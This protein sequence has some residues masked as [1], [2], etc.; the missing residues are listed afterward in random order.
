MNRALNNPHFLKS[1]PQ[2]FS[3]QS[4]REIWPISTFQVVKETH[5]CLKWVLEQTP[6]PT[7]IEAQ[8]TGRKLVVENVGEFCVEWHLA[9][10][11]KTV[12]CLY[13]FSHGASSVHSYMYC[14]QSKG[15][16]R[17]LST[18]QALEPWRH[19]QAWN[20]GLFSK[21]IQVN[22]SRGPGGGRS[23]DGKWAPILNIP[24]ECVHFCTLHAMCRTI[25]KI[26]HLQISYVWLMKDQV[27]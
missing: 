2:F 21:S 8:S 10:D 18:V 3:V 19:K 25:E 14:W 22:S 15:E 9:C 24:M 17:Q 6:I 13:G 27:E 1:D 12:K 16:R 5:E 4:E 26:I 11:M 23:G 20:G 7:V